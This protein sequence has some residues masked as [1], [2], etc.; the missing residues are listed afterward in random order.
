MQQ[1]CRLGCR[2]PSG[3]SVV[4]RWL[5]R[6]RGGGVLMTPTVISHTPLRPGAQS[7]FSPLRFSSFRFFWCFFSFPSPPPYFP[8]PLPLPSHLHPTP[9]LPPLI[10]LPF[11][12]PSFL[13]FPSSHAFLSTLLLLS[14]LFPLL[15]L[16]FLYLAYFLLFLL[17]I[18][19]SLQ[20]LLSSFILFHPLC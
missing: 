7:L 10:S 2:R 8:F 13:L 15:Y 3:G 1:A 18:V 19:Q 5:C 6:R 12:F 20:D 11:P 4:R 14:T 16:I 17:G 9:P